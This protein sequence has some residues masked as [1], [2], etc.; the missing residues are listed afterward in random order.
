MKRLG[1]VGGIG[2]ESTIDYYRLLVQQ[3]PQRAHGNAPSIVIH[4]I[5]VQRAIAMLE[6]DDRAALAAYLLDA[7]RPL[8]AAGSDF[9]ILAANTPHLVFDRLE[10][11]SPLPLLSIVEAT[12]DAIAARG[13]RRVALFG[14]GFTMRSGMYAP[15]LAKRGIELILPAAAEQQFIHEKYLGELLKNVFADATREEIYRI[16][17]RMRDDDGIDAVVL[18]GTELPILLR[19]EAHEGVPLYDTTRLHVERVIE[20][21]VAE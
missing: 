15:P 11:D 16:V 3:Y 12:A 2:P 9:A 4:S 21:M 18:A 7:I 20:E 6:A 14:T 19:S 17:R 8:A 5:D 13:A 1:I 10:R